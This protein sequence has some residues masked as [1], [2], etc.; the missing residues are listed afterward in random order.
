MNAETTQ[1]SADGTV[2]TEGSLSTIRFERRLDHPIER[3]WAA[4]TEPRQMVRWWGEAE[5]DL[6]EGGR[7]FVRWL[8]T[9][10]DGNSVEMDARITRLDVPRL[11]VTDGDDHGEIRWELTPDGDGTLLRFA[12]TLELPEEYR[13]KHP[14]GWHWHLDAL[15]EVLAGGNPDPATNPGW[16]RLHELYAA[17]LEGPL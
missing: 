9:D 11:L 4:L 15:A 10:E 1:G 14:A 12:S 17:K 5:V 3:V 13:S 6:V 8:N 16:Q 2:A 7:F